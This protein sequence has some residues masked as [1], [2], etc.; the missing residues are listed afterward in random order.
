MLLDQEKPAWAVDVA[1]RQAT[2]RNHSCTHLLQAALRGV[3]GSHVKQ[4]SSLVTPEAAA[5]RLT[6][7]AAMTPEGNWLGSRDAVNEAIMQN[8]PVTTEV[9]GLDAARAKGATALFAEKYGSEVRVVT[10]PG[11]SMELCAAR[12]LRP[13]VR[14]AAS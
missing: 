9:M 6:H 5:F 7:I 1:V 3:L 10:V 4:A 8:S 14:P 11:V 2:A 12:I 13:P